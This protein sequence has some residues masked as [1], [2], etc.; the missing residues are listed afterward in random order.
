MY[1]TSNGQKSELKKD[2]HPTDEPTVEPTKAQAAAFWTSVVLY[3]IFILALLVFLI[4]GIYT[5]FKK[6]KN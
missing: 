2:E 3:D 4:Y 6:N 1:T 5:L